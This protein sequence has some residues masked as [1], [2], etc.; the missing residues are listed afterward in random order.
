[1]QLCD[2]TGERIKKMFRKVDLSVSSYDTAWM[3]RVPSSVS[4]HQA[5]PQFPSCLNWV[6]NNQLS[7]GS[8]GLRDRDETLT[9]DAL[10]ST[11]AC[12]LALKQWGTGERQINKGITLFCTSLTSSVSLVNLAF[13]L[14]YH[15]NSRL[16]V[17]C[18]EFCF[19][20]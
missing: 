6:L 12:V 1:M 5:T 17:Y 10:S 14:A 2:G 15:P 16:G 3:A 8:W 20:K 18:F 19:C 11:L 13:E 4:P 7:D 9:M